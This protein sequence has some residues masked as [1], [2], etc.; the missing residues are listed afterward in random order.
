MC[1]QCI[2]KRICK[3]VAKEMNKTAADDPCQHFREIPPLLSATESDEEY[4]V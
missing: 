2:F 1:G 4:L 3:L